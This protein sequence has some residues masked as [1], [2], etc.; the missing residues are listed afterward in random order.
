MKKFLASLLAFMFL[1]INT[2]DAAT[3]YAVATGNFQGGTIW[4]T[5]SGGTATAVTPLSTDDVVF[6]THSTGTVTIGT[7]SNCH[8]FTMTAPGAGTITMGSTAVL[9][10]YGSMTLASGMTFAPNS[11]SIINFLSTSSGQTITSAAYHLGSIVFNGISGAWQ[12]QDN[13]DPVSSAILTLTNGALDTNGQSIGATNGTSFS[14]NNSNVRSLTLGTTSWSLPGST[15]A[16]MWDITNSTGMTLSA[17]S[18]T[19]SF[20]SLSGNSGVVFSGG[21]LTYGVL[22]AA[23]ISTGTL[24]INGANTFSS[25][26][27]VSVNGAAN[28]TVIFGANQTITGTWTING[29]SLTTRA[30]AKSSIIGTP[31]IISAGTITASYLD[32][33]DITGAGAANWDLHSITGG[34]GDGGGNSGITFN[35]PK[36]AYMKAGSSSRNWSTG[37]W[38]TTSGG[39]TPISPAMPLIQDTAILDANS[40]TAG[41]LSITPDVT[42][43]GGV[44]FTGVTHAP[45]F[46]H[47]SNLE[48]Y[49]SLIL[50]PSVLLT[51]NSSVTFSGAGNTTIDGGGITWLGQVLITKE[52]TATISLARNFVFNSTWTLTINSGIFNTAGY[53]VTGLNG[54]TLNSGTVN[55]DAKISGSP[56]ILAGGNINDVGNSGELKG[57]TF[58]C[59]GGTHTIRKLTLSSTFAISSACALTFPAGGNGTWATSWT[60]TGGAYSLMANG[61]LVKSSNSYVV[62][63]SGGSFTFGN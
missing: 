7:A 22:S 42:R 46:N 12:L 11:S 17:A 41:S 15:N 44:D 39:S 45:N 3:Y 4:A 56:I 10:V 43:I 6:D 19:L 16:V 21:G 50:D 51:A 49:G 48:I 33:R 55:L 61:K 14:S 40:F 60:E 59:T 8:N 57:T 29:N 47:G 13:L 26:T 9:N 30:F 38:E 25:L 52:P 20:R 24:Q 5:S 63:G 18:S 27:T 31:T 58:S 62:T 28:G 54:F 23:T 36:N 37:P 1:W 53:T 2:S 34:A 35:T 32:L